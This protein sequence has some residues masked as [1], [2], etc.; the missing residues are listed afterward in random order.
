M[1]SISNPFITTGYQGSEY[2]CNREEE[3]GVLK[4]NLIN[5]QSS[6]LIAIRRIGKT[7]LIRHVLAQLPE[8]HTGIYLDILPT[9]NLKE[10][11]NVLATAVFS[12]LPEQ[13]KSGNRI[14][15]FIK[16]LRPVIAFDPLTGFPQLTVDARP[17]EAERHIQS[18]LEY[19]EAYPQKVVI[20]IDEFQQILNYPEK[21]TDA[22]LRSI[23]QSL[24]NV[25]FIFSGSQQHLMTQLFADP[26]RPFYQSAGFLKIDKIKADVYESF[27]RHHF[28][29]AGMTIGQETVNAML[30]WADHHTYYVQL[31]CNRVYA[32][33]SGEVESELWKAQAAR[34]LQEQEIVFFKY[35]DLL[36][37]QQWMLLKAIAHEGIVFYPTSK[38]FIGK[39][40]LGSPATVLRS[41]Q[42]LTDKEMIYSDYSKE[43]QL[44]YSVYDILFRRWM[45]SK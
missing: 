19:L 16:S 6:T 14:L 2:F 31:L 20:A 40:D 10:F 32:A 33:A 1:A 3:T 23:I 26:S 5:G 18:V 43:G 22:F 12:T 4:N 34:L 35:R 44:F 30:H 11:L 38:V 8:N 36:T 21:N 37:K 25:R 15:D 27:I 7:G 28:E 41:L 24:N 45:Q 9:E 29:K 13:S 42:A 17:G 39:Y